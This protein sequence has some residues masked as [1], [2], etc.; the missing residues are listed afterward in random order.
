MDTLIMGKSSNSSDLQLIGT[1]DFCIEYYVNL[2]NLLLINFP[3]PS[4][5]IPF[6]VWCIIPK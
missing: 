3:V 4:N 5:M 1:G 2:V 6:L